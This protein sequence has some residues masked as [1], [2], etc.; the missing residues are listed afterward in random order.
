L[1]GGFGVGDFWKEE[2]AMTWGGRRSR[3]AGLEHQRWEGGRGRARE[4]GQRLGSAHGAE[5]GGLRGE[6]R[7]RK[8]RGRAG[9]R[10]GVGWAKIRKEEISLF[11][12]LF[13]IFKEIFKWILNSLLNLN[14]TTQY[15][16]PM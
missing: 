3:P 14:Q 7:P 11:L 4:L 16:N 13:K 2:L 8:E 12:F 15:K 1:G 10:E 6:A 9:V 5:R